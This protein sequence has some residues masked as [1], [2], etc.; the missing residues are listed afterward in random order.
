MFEERTSFKKYP[1][2]EMRYFCLHKKT[3]QKYYRVN[4]FFYNL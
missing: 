1:I 2:N 4:L 3:R